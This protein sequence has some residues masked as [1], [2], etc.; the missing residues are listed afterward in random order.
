[1]ALPAAGQPISF[2]DINDEL[3]NSSQ[4][5]LDLKSA[6]EDLGESAAPF[7]MD[8]LAGLSDDGITF[9]AFAAAQG[10]GQGEIDVSWTLSTPSGVSFATNGFVLKGS[11]NS[12]MSS[13]TTELQNSNGAGSPFTDSSLGNNTQRYYQATTTTTA[14]TVTNSSI[15]NATTQVAEVDRALGIMADY[16]QTSQEGTDGDFGNFLKV[17]GWATDELIQCVENTLPSEATATITEN[18][19]SGGDVFENRNT[20]TINLSA[21]GGFSDSVTATV[22][23]AQ[24]KADVTFA[25]NANFDGDD[26]FWRNDTDEKIHQIANNTG[27]ISNTISYTPAT[28][29]LSQVSKD[30]NSVTVRATGNTQ[31]ANTLRFYKDSTEV[32]VTN[33]T[34]GAVGNTSVTKDQTFS[35]LA[36]GTTF[37]FKVRGENA[38]K[39][40]ADSNTLNITT[41]GVGLSPTAVSGEAT[42]SPETVVISTVVTVGPFEGGSGTP[43]IKVN[44]AS[45]TRYKQATTS[46]GLSSA[47]FTTPTT[48]SGG[49]TLTLDGNG[50]VFLQFEITETT[51]LATTKSYTFFDSSLSRSMNVSV[52]AR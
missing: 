33:H 26:R 42:S 43:K 1:M 36:Q 4:A 32:A 30:S 41:D 34:K 44:N 14:G 37:A 10:S 29:T 3:G 35:S 25:N 47:S 5:T 31:V 48:S 9:S 12:D 22:N 8:E 13:P 28:L 15:V 11:A 39:N 46:S 6:S 21:V 51:G 40:G 24:T 20:S 45:N 7:G 16:D 17:K 19:G 27:A 49:Q 23:G 18:P 2:K 50:Q 52:T 38:E